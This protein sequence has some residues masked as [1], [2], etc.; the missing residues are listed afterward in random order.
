MI[1]TIQLSGKY[2]FL[3]AIGGAL[4][5]TGEILFRG[6]SHWS[7][8]L[9]G[10]LCFLY[11]G[12]QNEFTAWNKPLILQIMQVEL[13]VL[14][15]EFITGCIVNLWLKWNVW[16][17]S[18]MPAN[19]AGQIC[20]PFALLFL[21]LCLGAIVLDDFLRYWFFYGEKPHYKWF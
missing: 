20:L 21:P 15:G 16:D 9:L 12:I 6:Y 18:N 4:Y 3:F 5:Y 13:F 2:L 1:R 11:A 7:M 8:F 14:I 17:Y 10:G 19:V